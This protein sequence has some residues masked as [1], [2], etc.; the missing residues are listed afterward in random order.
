MA[1]KSTYDLVCE[2]L[3]NDVLVQARASN[4]AFISNMAGINS[5]HARC[6]QVIDK[7]IAEFDIDKARAQSAI[8][9]VSQSFWLTKSNGDS[10]NVQ[11]GTAQLLEVLRQVQAKK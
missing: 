6:A 1:E 3:A 2:Q 10:G 8:D 7:R 5:V 11:I 4:Q 9:P